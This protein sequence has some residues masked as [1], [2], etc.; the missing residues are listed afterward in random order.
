MWS[1]SKPYL[2]NLALSSSIFIAIA[3]IIGFIPFGEDTM[4]T[5]DLGQQYIDFYS[6][7][8]DT[9]FNDTSQLFY[10]FEK[11]IG[12]EMIGLW[13]YYLLSPFN[14][15]FLFFAEADLA[16]AVTLITYLKLMA[17][18][19]TF[20]FLVRRKYQ[21][22]TIPAIL[23]SQTY[24]FMSYS[25]V[26]LLNIMWLDGLVLLPL[27]ALGLD[28][29][30]NRKNNKLYIFSLA[31]LLMANYYIGY[32][33]CL[34]L[35]FYSLYSIIENQQKF[36]LKGLMIDYF[37]FIKHS[38]IAVLIAGIILLPTFYSL[39][40]NK[41]SY[42]SFE[43]S[44]DTVHTLKDV[45]S[46]FFIGSF[47]F[48][49]MSSGS[50]NLYAG[51]I[52]LLLVFLYW[53][54]RKI[55]LSEKIVSL[56][57]FSMFFAS[58]H[59]EI[60]DKIWHGGQFPIW[61]HFRFSFVAS[62]FLIMLAVKAF[63]AQPK[64][65][66]T[67][68]LVL[69]TLV[70]VA[71]SMYYYVYNEYDFLNSINIFVT[72]IVFLGLL[73]VLQL[74]F[75][76]NNFRYILLLAIVTVELTAN[77]SLIL[78]DLNYVAESKFKDY[79][80]TLDEAV[81]DIR[82]DQ[83]DF[84]RINKTYQRT[85]DEAMFTHY[86]GLDHFGSTIEAH[87]PELFGYLGLPDGNGFV[88]YTNGTLFTDDF[89]NVRYHLEPTEQSSD[90]TLEHEYVLYPRATDLDNQAYSI[91]QEADRYL[92]REN[93][94]RLALAIEVSDEIADGSHSFI[95]HQPIY[96]QE[97]LLDL[98]DF[99]GSGEPYFTEHAMDEASYHNIEVS[100][101]GDGDYYTYN[102]I[103]TESD[104]EAYFEINF[105]TES[106]N[107]YYF[108]LPSQYDDETV[109]LSLNGQQYRFYTPY[110][111]RQVTNASYLTIRPD[112]IF[113][114]KMLEDSLS[115]NLISLYEFDQARFDEM[116]ATKQEGQFKISHFKQNYIEG[117]VTIQQDQGYLLFTIP[118]DTQ[119]KI[120]IDG[121]SVEPEAVLNE[122]LMA[123]PITSGN[124]EITLHYLPRSIWFGISASL[125][126][127]GLLVINDRWVS[128]FSKKRV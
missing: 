95:Q 97:L 7:F 78:S 80:A 118:F 60:I 120:T 8:R 89:F 41:G 104:D 44:W 29:I 52:V 17:A 83:S 71:F 127:L 19:T 72:L 11:A 14:I 51:M 125:L 6:L 126:G 57:I 70:I 55:K 12:G 42:M 65:Y 48:D 59:Y 117:H 112:Q 31:L 91:I 2:L 45:T 110:R 105:A 69:A 20:M 113:K 25:M 94:E 88:T 87:V 101:V 107:P 13:A 109:A 68:H 73:I 102:K 10:S 27:I 64:Y 99:Q 18:S 128:D 4:L 84:Y 3:L 46:K 33:V 123:I 81:T 34:F 121:Q 37:S 47:I 9:V 53:F 67:Y 108:T 38:I 28:H 82:Q 63:K 30:L 35:A 92:I 122:T 54:N 103:V 5:I 1:K 23:F 111:R 61:Y 85:K 77:A 21:L 49:E 79:V 36:N 24:A 50:P 98:I 96:N 74:D 124:H 56:G 86:N 93:E 106:E 15:I 116:I 119:W 43:F 62:F 75:L 115:A 100:N 26:Y 114:V 16:L 40:Q 39:T 58:F 66:P 32:M 76:D 22:E 90:H